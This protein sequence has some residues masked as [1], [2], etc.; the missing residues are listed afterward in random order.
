MISFNVLIMKF[1]AALLCQFLDDI[2]Y[3]TAFRCLQE[4]SSNDAMDSLYPY[5]FDVTLLEFVIQLH[6]KKGETQRK[7]LAVR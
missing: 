3:A 6:H 7:A 5:M 4:R 2:D 1:Q